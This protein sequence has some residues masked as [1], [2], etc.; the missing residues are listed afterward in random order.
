MSS[1][2]VEEKIEKT[3]TKR[4]LGEENKREKKMSTAQKMVPVLIISCV[5]LVI[6]LGATLIAFYQLKKT[7]KQSSKTL[8]SV[9]AS[10]YYSMVDSVNNLQVNADKFETLTSSNAQRMVLKDME[11]DC[12][13]IIAGLSVLPIDAE[14]SNSSIKFFNQVSGMCEAYITQIDKGESL[15]QEQ[16]LLVDKA[17]YALSI[18]KSKLNNHNDMIRQGDYEFISTS[19]FDDEGVT[20]F[21]NSIGGLTANEVEYPTM[22]F[23]GPFSAALETKLIKGLTKTEIT[24]EQALEYLK[25]VV[26]A[27]Q[28]VKIEYLRETQGDFVTYDYQI[29]KDGVDYTAQIT[30]RQGVLL[31]LSGYAETEDPNIS[32]K[33]AQEIAQNFAKQ[34]GFGDMVTTWLEVKENIAYINLA[35][36]QGD[37]VLYPDLVK[38]K[39]DMFGQNVIGF[40]ARNYAFNHTERDFKI[41]VTES[42]AERKLGFDYVVL[43]TRKAIIALENDIEVPVYE[44]ACDRIGGLYYYY[45]DANTGDI[46]KILKVVDSNGTPLLI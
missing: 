36:M 33:K 26:Y 32:S 13:Y 27:N 9:Y 41:T 46:V 4:D 23:D 45:I 2:K 10:S 3:T 17:E 39:V 11:Q 12:A 38:V 37:V 8:E 40:E 35:P 42:Q 44:F 1:N 34:V 24:Q 15:T 31:T 14:N 19:V 43:N 25:N 16:L 18:I 28:N 5:A 22:I 20:Q 29:E 21:S 7:D 30:K 6:A